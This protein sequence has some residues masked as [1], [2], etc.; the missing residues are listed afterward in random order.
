MEG[1]I[2]EGDEVATATGDAI[3]RD[4]AIIAAA[5]RV[6]GRRLDVGRRA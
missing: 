2:R 4:A 5:Q 6:E 1:L 3:A